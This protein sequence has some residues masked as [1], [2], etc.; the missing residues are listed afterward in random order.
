MMF[1]IRTISLVLTACLALAALAA[2]ANGAS[3]DAGKWFGTRF[4]A[5]QTALPPFSFIYGDKPSSDLLKSWKVTK[6]DKKL[7]SARTQRT[8]TYTDP[9]TGLVVRCVAVAYKDFPTVEW[10]LYFKNTGKSDSPILR[11]ILALDTS[12]TRGGA[13]EFAL[14]HFTGTPCTPADYQPF[15]TEL[16]P[17]ATKRIS[18]AAGRP[19]SS[20]LPYFNI[21]WPGAGVIMAVGWP[22][23]WSAIFARDNGRN[24]SL[25]AGQELTHFTLHPGEEVRTPMMVMQFYKGDWIDAQ[26]VWRRWMLAH[27]LPRPG[28]K[29]PPVQ[30]A[31]CSSWQFGE[32]IHA[33]TESQKL[34]IDGYVNNKF[35]LDYWWMDAGWYPHIEKEGWQNTGTWEVDEKRFPG[36]F[37]PI[38]D[39]AHAKGVKIIV[40]FEPERVTP[41]TWLY[42]HPEW[43]LTNPKEPNG[44]KLL[45][46]G[47]TEAH[48]WLTDHIDKMLTEQGIDLYRQDFNIDPLDFWRGADTEDRQGITEIRYVEGYL[49][50]WDALRQRHPNMLIDSCASGGRRNDLETLRR[51]VPLLRSDF[52]VEPTSQQCHTYGVAFWYPYYGTGT[53]A[54]DAYQFRS[55]MCPTFIAC[56]DMRKTD[57]PFDQGRKLVNQWKYELGPNF[58]GDY[59]P[60]TVY[61]LDKNVWM[62][63]QWNRPEVGQG[64][65]QAFRREESPQDSSTFKLRGLDP[66]A[67]YEVKNLDQGS[68]GQFTGRDLM[69]K[70]LSVTLKTKAAAAVIIYSKV[71]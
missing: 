7:D 26:N 18:A 12:L 41:G 38:T 25:R 53:G 60:L 55:Q 16:G 66:S 1:S 31:A 5:V 46:M 50:Y 19:S 35:P 21:E 32:M 51:S 20:D 6:T 37:K 10:T 65:V 2:K 33:N 23:Q 47:N 54:M 63:W 70:G 49:A 68:L 61:S 67:R 59:Y 27:N 42:G 22:G 40:W 28:G 3:A 13:G 58:F 14:H 45:N 48:K 29:L 56:Y 34:F 11:K 71:K 8:I 4:G 39:Y 24:L 30:M 17:N 52:L 43:L 15:K 62:A 57:L 64:A 36:G 44:W 69:D 9:S